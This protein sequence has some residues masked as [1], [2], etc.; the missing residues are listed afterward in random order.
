MP[1]RRSIVSMLP[2]GTVQS[3]GVPADK[4]PAPPAPAKKAPAKKG[5]AYMGNQLKQAKKVKR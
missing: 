1:A 4:K 3:Y 2:P 5:R